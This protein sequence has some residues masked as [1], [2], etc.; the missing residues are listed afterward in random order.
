MNAA[1][2]SSPDFAE[3]VM[4]EFPYQVIKYA[5][6]AAEREMLSDSNLFCKGQT[7]RLLNAKRGA[8]PL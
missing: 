7:H 5:A 3:V 2:I 8:L 1:E 6:R 4:E